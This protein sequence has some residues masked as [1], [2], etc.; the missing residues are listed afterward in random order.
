MP[1]PAYSA[2]SKYNATEISE[3]NNPLSIDESVC[4]AISAKILKR[5][6]SNPAN[7]IKATPNKT[8]VAL[9]IDRLCQIAK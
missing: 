9:D 1:V 2:G 5:N 4:F 3:L 6:T 8:T 7:T